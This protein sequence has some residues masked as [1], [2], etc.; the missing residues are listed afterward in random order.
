LSGDSAR[1]QAPP[2]RQTVRVQYLDCRSEDGYREFR[3][4][5]FLPEG[6]AEVRLRI[7][8][9][10]LAANRLLLQDGPDV[11]YQ[12][13]LQ[14]LSAGWVPSGS[15]I[16]VEDAQLAAYRQAH[17]PAP[18]R[19]V[20][21]RPSPK[22]A[23]VPRPAAPEK[24]PR[25]PVAAAPAAAEA[26]PVF[27]EGQRVSHEVFG[28][29]VTMASSEGR[30]SVQFDDHGVRTFVTSMLELEVLSAPHEWE[31]GPRGANRPRDASA[32]DRASAK[33]RA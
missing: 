26:A 15:L 7:P 6:P 3:Y 25:L 19:V 29:G 2:Q 18:R 12:H 16:T 28:A 30:T 20:T 17:T 14:M 24:H 4:V 13:L 10:A 32:P 1:N 21:P 31:A 9:A 8:V 27:D 33:R 11:C 23:W 5:L 22:R